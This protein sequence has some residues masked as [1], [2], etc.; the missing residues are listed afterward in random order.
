MEQ[1]VGL[2]VSLKETS[3]CVVDG[4]G[5]IVCET[6]V[7][8]TPETIAKFIEKRAPS[9]V[10]VGLESGLLST[11]L[12]HGLRAL[13][14]PVVC[15]DARHAASALKMQVNKTD[16][17]DAAGLAQIVRTGWYREVEVKSLA[18]HEVRAVLLA[19]SRLVASRRD[20]ENQMRGLLKPFG[21]LVGKVRGKGFEGRV[22]ELI[23]DAPAM[24]EVIDALLLARRTLCTQVARL[25]VRVRMLAQTIA[26]CRRLMTVPGVGPI[27]ALAYVTVID[28]PGR[29]RKGRSVGAYLGL[30]PRRY[31]S[32]EVDRAGRI[33]KC[34]DGLVRTLLF[35][36]AGV[37]LTRVQRMSPLKAWGLR[38][39]KRIGAKK[40][41]VA[42]ARKLAVI[43]HCMWTDGTEFW[44]TKEDVRA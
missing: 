33:S 29:F 39:A 8:T 5:E 18:C 44:W 35:E 4:S 20:L 14:V 12:W 36:A 40:A 34:G 25:D 31:Q 16:R 3:I 6:S 15:L 21:L 1:Y 32:G 37:L 2:D 13:D 42:V 43:L 22:R 38:L 24:A 9:A 41:K 11:W 30:T 10:R 28:D 23:A 17:N 27:T 26:P 7:G 19:R